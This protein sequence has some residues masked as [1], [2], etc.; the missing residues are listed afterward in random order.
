MNDLLIPKKIHKKNRVKEINYHSIYWATNFKK[1]LNT[2]LMDWRNDDALI[3]GIE[4]KVYSLN[5]MEEAQWMIYDFEQDNT[6]LRS[7]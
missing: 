7:I 4:S 5:P 1:D 3:V 2:Q 6:E